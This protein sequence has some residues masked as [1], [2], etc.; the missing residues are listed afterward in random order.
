MKRKN[1][2]VTWVKHHKFKTLGLLGVLYI[3]TEMLTIPYERIIQLQTVNPLKTALMLQREEQA[4]REGK[5]LRIRHTWVPLSKIP[6]HVRQAIIVGEDGTFYAHHGVDWHEVW[7]SVRTN[8]E[9]GGFARGA[10]TITQQLAK[11]LYLSSA[12]TPMRKFREMLMAFWMEA[13]LD[14][15]RILELYLNIIEWGPGIFGIEAAA[16]QYFHKTTK[17]LSPEE[18]VRLAA[19]IPR[20]LQYRP[21]ENSQYVLK[22]KAILLK[23]L[24]A[25]QRR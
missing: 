12:K 15:Q 17:H 3:L 2:V 6:Q 4:S 10:S 20:P 22:K 23:R 16:Q 25:R 14:K 18:G 8:F 19:V 7:E 13:Q 1:C 9:Q 24:S 11:N 5:K 21:N